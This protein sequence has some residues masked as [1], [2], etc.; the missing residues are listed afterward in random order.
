MVLF[1]QFLIPHALSV[2]GCISFPH[3]SAFCLHEAQQVQRLPLLWVL[4]PAPG[5]FAMAF[6]RV[7]WLSVLILSCCGSA[8]HDPHLLLK[9]PL[10]EDVSSTMDLILILVVFQLALGSLMFLCLLRCLRNKQAQQS[11]SCNSCTKLLQKIK[12][13]EQTIQEK[14]QGTNFQNPKGRSGGTGDWPNTVYIAKCGEVWHSSKDCAESR[15][16]YK[17]QGKRPCEIC[18][19]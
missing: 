16:Q 11:S 1:L 5:L 7:L 15:S 17:V 13:L 9:F 19:R 2:F 6:H 18:A 3:A 14:G 8:G 4:C 10:I 12:K